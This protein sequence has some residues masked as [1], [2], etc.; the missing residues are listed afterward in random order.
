[1]RT[2]FLLTLVTAVCV[3]LSMPA[4]L[5][6]EGRLQIGQIKPTTR[7]AEEAEDK[8]VTASLPKISGHEP[9]DDN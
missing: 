8:F 2:I 5:A 1:M 9:H 7:R 6:E 3:L 4:A